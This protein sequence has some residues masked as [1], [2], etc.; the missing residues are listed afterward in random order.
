[1]PSIASSVAGFIHGQ[2]HKI[3]TSD[4]FARAWIRGNTG[5][6]GALVKALSRQGG[7]ISVTNGQVTIDLAPFIDIVK[8][9]L[10]SRGF[11]LVNS[12][13]P[14]HPTFALFS[15]RELVKA[16]SLYRLINDLKYVL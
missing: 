2:V 1:G 14:I 7:A 15:S 5:A 11:T 16:Q 4:R 3:V 8:H 13:P 10:A 9:N 12:L 6:H